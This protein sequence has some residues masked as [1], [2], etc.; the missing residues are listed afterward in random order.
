MGLTING[1][2]DLQEKLENM[3]KKAPAA[4]AKFLAQEGELLRGRAAN[5]TPVDTG[6]LRNSWKT[7][8]IN[9]QRVEVSNNTEYAAHVEYGHRVKIHG[10]WTGKVVKGKKMLHKAFD[11]TKDNFLEDG[12]AILGAIMK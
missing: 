3:A 1:L 11:E 8:M 5:N 10:K 7:R 12:V 9:P 4:G 6:N 2:D